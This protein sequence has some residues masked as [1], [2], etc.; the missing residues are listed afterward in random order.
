MVLEQRRSPSSLSLF[1][2]QFPE[3]RPMLVG[4]REICV[5]VLCVLLF[6]KTFRRRSGPPS[7]L[8]HDVGKK[9]SLRS[10]THSLTV[11]IPI[12]VNVH[13]RHVISIK[14]LSNLVC[15]FHISL[16]F[17]CQFAIFI[18]V[19]NF[20]VSIYSSYIEVCNFHMRLQVSYAFAIFI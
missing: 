11:F 5:S 18:S 1:V 9:L 15:N 19:C 12:A 14:S 3:G 4:R 8:Q 2:P 7:Q 16:Q 17:S 6:V 13:S 10:K 20:H